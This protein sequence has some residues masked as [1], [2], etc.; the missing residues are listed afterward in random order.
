MVKSFRKGQN[1]ACPESICVNRRSANGSAPG[2]TAGRVSVFEPPLS[3][4]PST[5]LQAPEKSRNRNTKHQAPN[6]KEI[7]SSKLQ[8]TAR[9]SSVELGAS[10]DFGAWCLV[11][12]TWC[13]FGAWNLEFGACCLGSQLVKIE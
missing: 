3:E 13:F 7:P 10:L 9:A 1:C 8:T 5:K 11:F 4:T 12:G 6:T 2:R